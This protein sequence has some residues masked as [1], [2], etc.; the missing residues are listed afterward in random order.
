MGLRKRSLRLLPRAESNTNVTQAKIRRNRGRIQRD[1]FLHMTQRLIETVERP[2]QC[3]EVREDGRILPIESYRN[4]Q[5]FDG[6]GMSPQTD[7]HPRTCDMN[8]SN[9]RRKLDGPIGIREGLIQAAKLKHACSQIRWSGRLVGVDAL[10]AMQQIERFLRL[11]EPQLGDGEI[12][13][14]FGVVRVPSQGLF[15]NRRRIRGP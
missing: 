4:L 1:N 3:S 10:G 8:L 9:R 11:L 2:A 5:R 7:E 14:Y 15:E 6:L 13:E 12:V